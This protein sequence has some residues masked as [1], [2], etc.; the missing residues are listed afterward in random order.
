MVTAP[1]K[2]VYRNADGE[3]VEVTSHEWATRYRSRGYVFAGP[4]REQQE[5]EQPQQVEE[6]A[7]P[8]LVVEEDATPEQPEELFRGV[9]DGRRRQR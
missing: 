2:Y 6:Q 8:E 5:T 7:T 9:E 1:D 3:E 4:A